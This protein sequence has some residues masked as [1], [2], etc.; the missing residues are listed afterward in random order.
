MNM[1]KLIRVSS[2]TCSFQF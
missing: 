1:L 2:I